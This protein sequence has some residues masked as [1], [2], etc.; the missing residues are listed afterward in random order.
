MDNQDRATSIRRRQRQA[1]IGYAVAMFVLFV[2]LGVTVSWPVAALIIVVAAIFGVIK[3][4]A[5]W[6]PR[7]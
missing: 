4:G 3:F 2:L 5:W 6:R 7:R 1:L